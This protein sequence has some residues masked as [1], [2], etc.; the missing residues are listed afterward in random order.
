VR[1]FGFVLFFVGA[2]R[3]GAGEKTRSPPLLCLFSPPSS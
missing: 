1:F 2:A 3:A